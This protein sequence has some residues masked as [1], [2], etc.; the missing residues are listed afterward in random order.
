MNPHPLLS[1]KS[2]VS[3]RRA[4]CQGHREKAASSKPCGSRGQVLSSTAGRRAGRKEV[5]E[6]RWRDRGRDE[7]CRDGGMGDERM[8]G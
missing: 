7:G 2:P 3:G 4:R 6:E 1:L 5:E 8:K